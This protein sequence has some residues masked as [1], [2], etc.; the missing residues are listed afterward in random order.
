[1]F[2]ARRQAEVGPTGLG[3]VGVA[4]VMEKRRDIYLREGHGPTLALG[5]YALRA[6]TW[7]KHRTSG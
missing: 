6:V 3:V 1:M 2:G 7:E 4:R 5:V